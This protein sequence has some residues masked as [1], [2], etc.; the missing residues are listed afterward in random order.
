MKK[1]PKTKSVIPM[2]KNGL[3]NHQSGSKNENEKVSKQVSTKQVNSLTW[4]DVVVQTN[5]QVSICV[6][7]GILKY[8]KMI[9]WY[10]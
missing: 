6:F 10:L 1:T 7:V 4:N 5:E 9:M 8:R 3:T 2:I